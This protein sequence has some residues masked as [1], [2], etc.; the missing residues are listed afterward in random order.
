MEEKKLK[1]WE[2]LSSNI[3]NFSNSIS[4]GI[5]KIG[6]SVEG[7]KSPTVKTEIG[8]NGNTLMLLGAGAVVL[9]LIINKGK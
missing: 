3:N 9:Y 8:I 4:G 1:W 6:D 2:K 5:T 7:F